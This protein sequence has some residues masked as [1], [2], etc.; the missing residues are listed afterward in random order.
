MDIN[1]RGVYFCLREEVAQIRKQGSK[2]SI[3]NC[4]S[5]NS[6]RGAA[7]QSLQCKVKSCDGSDPERLL[8]KYGPFLRDCL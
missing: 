8:V 4:G 3:I 2:G 5:T 1:V 7:G 6:H